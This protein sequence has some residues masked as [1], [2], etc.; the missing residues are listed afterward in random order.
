[1]KYRTYL[2]PYKCFDN[3]E[4]SPFLRIFEFWPLL[5]AE[6]LSFD[7]YSI[8]SLVSTKLQGPV[9]S[10]LYKI[11]VPFFEGLGLGLGLVCK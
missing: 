5:F 10:N 2:S 8:W 9:S 4:D 6:L 7:T 11:R 1:M 3:S